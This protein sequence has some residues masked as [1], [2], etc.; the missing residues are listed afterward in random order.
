M[1]RTY[2]SVIRVNSQSGKGGVAYLLERDYGLSLPRRLQ[3]EFS[4]IV[5][6]ATD[7]SGKEIGSAEIWSLFEAEY[8]G[9]EGRDFAYH[10]HRLA[11]AQD[12]SDSE[13]LEVTLTRDGVRQQCAGRGNGPI[14]ALVQ[15]AG[16]AHRRAL[17]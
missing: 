1:G 7:D 8:L 11:T 6:Q 3:V 9:T 14:D 4:P 12:G 5:Q 17:L 16:T 2:D 10:S 13:L 15:R